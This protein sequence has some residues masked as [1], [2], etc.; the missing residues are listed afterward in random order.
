MIASNPKI[1]FADVAGVRYPAQPG[2]GFMTTEEAAAVL[3]MKPG[4]ARRLLRRRHLT[5]EHY[6]GGLLWSETLVCCVLAKLPPLVQTPPQGWM[7]RETA[8]RRLNRSLRTLRAW[9]ADGKLDYME[10]R[11]GARR[12]HLYSEQNV[13]ALAAKQKDNNE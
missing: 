3:G 6:Q 5:P 9:E 10:V 4:A 12:C 8:C 2:A 7:T 11:M 13:A 1:R